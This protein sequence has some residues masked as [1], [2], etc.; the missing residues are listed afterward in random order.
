MVAKKRSTEGSVLIT[1]RLAFPALAKQEK[2]GADSSSKPRYA[3]N[4]LIPKEGEEHKLVR[5][6][7]YELLKSKLSASAKTPERLDAI[8]RG[9]FS[10][11]K[12]CCVRDGDMKAYDG[13]EGNIVISAYNTSPSPRPTCLDKMRQVITDPEEIAQT[14]YSG[15]YVHAIINFWVQDNKNGKAL[16]ASCGGVMFYKDG[17][18]FSGAAVAKAEDFGEIEIEEEDPFDKSDNPLF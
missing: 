6:V 8:I 11:P 18:R 16:R 9:I 4:L 7:T 5:E 15:C 17:D 2:Y 1:G 3:I 10:D 13:F 14:F 12:G